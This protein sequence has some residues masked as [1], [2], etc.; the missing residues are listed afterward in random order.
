MY[1]STAL[2]S[3]SFFL[4]HELA[5]KFFFTKSFCYLMDIDAF[6]CPSADSNQ[7]I[8]SSQ[9]KVSHLKHFPHHYKSIRLIHSEK[10]VE[11]SWFQRDCYWYGHVFVEAMDRY[12]LQMTQRILRRRSVW[13]PSHIH[14][15]SLFNDHTLYLISSLIR[16]LIH[17]LRLTS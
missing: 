17:S 1:L 9:I 2:Y 10:N 16:S 4:F 3:K 11:K 13:F 5:L 15:S 7:F 6:F 14:I 8:I 12:C